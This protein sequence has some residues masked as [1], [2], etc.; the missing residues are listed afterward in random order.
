MT[1]NSSFRW[2]MRRLATGV[3]LAVG[4]YGLTAA[5]AWYHYGRPP[6]PDAGER[7]ELL[8]RFMPVYDVV[9]RHEIAVAAPAP[10]TLEAGKEQDLNDSAIVRLIFKAREAALGATPPERE[11]P[12]GLIAAVRSL[13]WGV[14]ADAPGREIVMG[15]VTKPWEANVTF[16]A[17][18][19]ET[20]RLQMLPEQ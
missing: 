2:A 19:P 7:D 6:A 15:A 5:V 14:L 10:V 20:F 8:D 13:G 18:P 17:L 12:R 3:G 4:V 11:Q 9:E 1:V 16:H